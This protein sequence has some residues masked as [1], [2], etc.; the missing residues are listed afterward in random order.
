MLVRRQKAVNLLLEKVRKMN[1]KSLKNL[2]SKDEGKS[3][4]ELYG[5][6]DKNLQARN[7]WKL[8]VINVF[9]YFI[10]KQI[11]SLDL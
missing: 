5:L 4:A 3:L 6:K 2:R 7:S 10:Y 8:L 9:H 11:D 1:K